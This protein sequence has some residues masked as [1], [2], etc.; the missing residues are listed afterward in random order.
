MS[1]ICEM[2]KLNSVRCTL[3]YLIEE[4]RGS[5]FMFLFSPCR[6]SLMENWSDI[7]APSLDGDSPF[8]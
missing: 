8:P 1:T 2:C 5:M 3:M 4:Y 6:I 7:C